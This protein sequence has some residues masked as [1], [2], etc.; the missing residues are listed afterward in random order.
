MVA[1]RNWTENIGPTVLM[2]KL[3]RNGDLAVLLSVAQRAVCSL[4]SLSDRLVFSNEGKIIINGRS[5]V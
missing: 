4:N 3:P 2:T 5:T 1:A